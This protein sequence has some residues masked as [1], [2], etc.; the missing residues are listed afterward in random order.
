MASLLANIQAAD[1]HDV[2]VIYSNRPETPENLRSHFSKNIRMTNIQM[3]TS[4][5]K[6]SSIRAL[7]RHVSEKKPD[8]IFLHSSFAGFIGRLAT[9]LAAKG[10]RI[11]YIPHCISF[12]RKDI[13]ASKK[14]TFVALE[15]IGAIKTATYIAC[16]RSEQMQI[17][18]L[19][20]FRE[21]VLVEN[22]VELTYKPERSPGANSRLVVTTVG[23]VRPQKDPLLF[24]QIAS[25]AHR[26]SLPLDFIWIGDGDPAMKAALESAGVTVT[27]WLTKHE[28]LNRLADSDIYLSTA[29]WEGMPVSIIEAQLI[30]VPVIASRCAGNVDCISNEKTG[31]LYDT[32]EEA[33]K[34]LSN[35]V[36]NPEARGNVASAALEI[37][38]VRFNK[39]RYRRQMLQ[40]LPISG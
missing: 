24:A 32:P 26:D 33:L 13:S 36:A 23:Q 18:K 10:T 28:V 6:L 35:L 4:R 20:P 17:Q 2:E 39:D 15:W 11:F 38:N 30:G 16:S 7:R 1:G 31:W 29:Q 14:L 21:C 8:I 37:A 19:I 25:L 34:S 5:E 22:A 40:Y 12:M 9:L 27:G 3:H